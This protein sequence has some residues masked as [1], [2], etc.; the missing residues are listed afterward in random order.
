MTKKPKCCDHNGGLV[1]TLLLDSIISRSKVGIFIVTN[2]VTE[3]S[4]GKLNELSNSIIDK[5]EM[6]VN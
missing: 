4:Q 2:V 1:R 3:Y 5:I 6:V